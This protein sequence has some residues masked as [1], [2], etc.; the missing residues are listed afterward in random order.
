MFI[1]SSF[2]LDHLFQGIGLHYAIV[3][4]STYGFLFILDNFL[5]CTCLSL[6]KPFHPGL[7]FCFGRVRIKLGTFHF[8]ILNLVFDFET[9]D[10]CISC[11]LLVHS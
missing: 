7:K 1:L 5:F 10:C 4:D 2:S 6:G 3:F 8:L 9:T 11:G